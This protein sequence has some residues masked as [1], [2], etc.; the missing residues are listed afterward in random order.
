MTATQRRESILEAATR[1]FA[2][3]GYAGTS[4]ATIADEAR[5]SQPYVIQMFGSKGHLFRSVYERADREVLRCL[6]TTLREASS[7]GLNSTEQI[8]RATSGCIDR[9]P[10]RAYI[11]IMMHGFL[12]GNKCPEVSDL[13]HTTMLHLY[14]I[15]QESTGCSKSQSGVVV[16]QLILAGALLSVRADTTSP[17]NALADLSTTVFGAPYGDR[18]HVEA[19]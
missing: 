13:A 7:L 18:V 11:Q 12:A 8:R 19:S 17:D 1:A 9:L 10:D 4:T 15:I 16:G 3:T 6:T 5:V 14:Q 2:R